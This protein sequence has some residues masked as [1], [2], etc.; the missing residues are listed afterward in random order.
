MITFQKRLLIQ[1]GKQIKM[2]SSCEGREKSEKKL[3]YRDRFFVTLE[4]LE[5]VN[6]LQINKDI[7][8]LN[9]IT[10]SVNFGS[11]LRWKYNAIIMH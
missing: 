10:A 4:N 6:K 5:T 3:I 7:I 1:L 9:F 2:F 11:P 8:I